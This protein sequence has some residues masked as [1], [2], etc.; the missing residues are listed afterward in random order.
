VATVVAAL[1]VKAGAAHAGVASESFQNVEMFR[2]GSGF[3]RMDLKT[4]VVIYQW[5]SW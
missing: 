2:V 5:D 4:N 1:C 3:V